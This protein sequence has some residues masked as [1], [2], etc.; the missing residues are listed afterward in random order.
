MEIK[1]GFTG[2]G[3]IYPATA[4]RRKNTLG[5]VAVRDRCFTNAYHHV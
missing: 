1:T 3:N 2:T 5:T 4:Y